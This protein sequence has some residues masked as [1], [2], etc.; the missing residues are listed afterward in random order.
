[1]LG[2]EEV[3]EQGGRMGRLVGQ[4]VGAGAGLFQLGRGSS[5]GMV[6]LTPWGLCKDTLHPAP[7]ASTFQWQRTFLSPLSGCPSGLWPG[8]HLLGGQGSGL[9]CPA[10]C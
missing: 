3:G 1:M 10:G 9:L 6:P 7:T 4:S 8:L 5:S 2:E